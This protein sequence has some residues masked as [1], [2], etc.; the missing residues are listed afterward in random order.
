MTTMVTV[1]VNRTRQRL[2]QNRTPHPCK[3]RKATRRS[4]RIQPNRMKLDSSSSDDDGNRTKR[5]QGRRKDNRQ[6]KPPV[7]VSSS[8]SDSDGY[9]QPRHILKPPKYDGSTPFETFWAQFR[10]CAGYN[11]WTKT[12]ELA[13]LRGALEKDAAQVLWD[14]GTESDGF[15]EEVNGH[16]ERP[17]CWKRHG[18]QIPDRSKE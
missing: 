1:T 4:V 6:S 3:T 10:N 13:Y 18:G 7:T 8:D 9:I 5:K 16:F 14:Y 12:E 17:L 2:K 11:R 15:V